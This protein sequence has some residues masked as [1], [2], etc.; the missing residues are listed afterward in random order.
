[1]ASLEYLSCSFSI[2]HRLVS[3]NI[4]ANEQFRFC[5]NVSTE[6]AIFKLIKSIFSAWNSKEYITGLFG[7]LTMVFD[8]AGH[9]I[10]I[11]NL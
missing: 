2:E 3:N 4:L 10:L 7:D 11:L 1:V 9:E 6:S 8:S 5:D